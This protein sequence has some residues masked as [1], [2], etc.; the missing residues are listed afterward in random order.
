MT[1]CSPEFIRKVEE[2]LAKAKQLGVDV[3][4]VH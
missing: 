1:G 4:T 2:R 3:D